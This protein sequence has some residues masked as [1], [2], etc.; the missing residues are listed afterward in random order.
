MRCQ[1]I[2][3]G[4]EN[5]PLGVPATAETDG[6]VVVPVVEH[7]RAAEAVGVFGIV[8]GNE[9]VAV[10]RVRRAVARDVEALERESVVCRLGNNGR[11]DVV[12]RDRPLASLTV[13][14]RVSTA[15]RLQ[16]AEAM[17]TLQTD[18]CT[19]LLPAC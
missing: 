2:H 7:G 6:R 4:Y 10:R 19:G 16:I 17:R 5:A 3:Q 18:C 9:R 8:T 11:D 14:C 1:R 13:H 15:L 12:V